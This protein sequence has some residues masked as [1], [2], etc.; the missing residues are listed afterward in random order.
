MYVPPKFAQDEDAAW[1]IVDGAGAGMLVLAKPEGLA[2]VFV[3]VIVSDDRSTVRSHV[4]RANPWWRAVPDGS[5]VLGLFLAA[6]A[7]VSPSRYPSTAE[8]PH[9]VPTWNYVAAEIRGRVTVH[10]DA[11]WLLEQV[12]DL[13]GHF[14]AGRDP[15][16]CVDEMDPAYRAGQLRAIVGVEIAVTSIEGKA[17]LSQNR[18]DVDRRNVRAQFSDGSLG[19]R[20]VAEWMSDE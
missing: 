6:S 20:V 1:R 17:K 13:T 12:R 2:S 10:E 7:Y 16:W 5:E 14:E 18:P 19:E 9:V 15:Q 11:D 3:P 4:A 8:D